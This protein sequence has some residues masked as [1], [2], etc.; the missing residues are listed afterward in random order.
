MRKL[1][2]LERILYI[3]NSISLLLLLCSYVSK[4]VSPIFFWQ[5]SF[6]GLIFPFLYIINILFL[7]Y[8]GISFKKPIWANIIILTIGF[9]NFKQYFGTSPNNTSSKDNIQVL[10]YNVR[11]FN[12]YNW[13]KNP[14]VK[15]DIYR[16]LEIE[17][18]EILCI[19][20][21]YSNNEIPKLGYPYKHIELE[22]DKKQSHMAIYSKYLQINKETVNINGKKMNNTCIY[23]DII[24]RDDTI[25]VYNIHLASNWFNI[26]DYSFMQNPKKDKF[27]DGI[28]GIMERMKKSFKKRAQEVE[29]IKQHISKS[30]YSIIVC[31]DLN[32]TPLSYAYHS[33]KG[34]LIDAFSY[35][36]KGIGNSFVDIPALR[37]DYIFHDSKFKSTNYQKH[38]KILSDHYPISCEISIP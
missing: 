28:L 7:I 14:N 17:N 16:F 29:L 36:G 35:S 1:S 21:F 25:R 13:L 37:I 26:A 5:I 15:E 33:I 19:Q 12:K 30:P 9:G 3:L 6:I 23:S 31:G 18:A 38:N 27:K 20:E 8:W 24:I 10:T 11:L 32:D 2:F 34:S 22:G 4:Y